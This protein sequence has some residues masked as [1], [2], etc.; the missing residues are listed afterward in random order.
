MVRSLIMSRRDLDFLLYEWLDVE[1]LTKRAA[2]AEHSRETFDAVLDLAEQIATE[3]FAPHNKKGDANEPR[4]RRQGRA[5]RRRWRKALTA[6]AEAG[7]LAGVDG[8]GARRHAAAARRRARPVLAWFQAANVGTSAYPFLT[9]GQ[10]QPAARARQPRAD[11]APT[12]AP[13]LEGRFFGTMACRSRRP[14]RRW[15]TSPPAPSRQDDGT[16][17]LIGTKM[18][19]SGGDHELTENIVH[20]VLAKIPGGAAR[21]SRASRCSSCRSS[22]STTTA[23][24]ASATTSCWPA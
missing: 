5:D 19:I 6:F 21:A 10:R 20:L 1:E 16:Y 3:H 18:W 14:A 15:P 23:R 2:F 4:F 11:R 12:S 8:R 24:S 22:W 13:M 9:D 17:R 7:L